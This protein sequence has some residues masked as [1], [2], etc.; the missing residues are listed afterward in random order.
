[1]TKFM[2]MIV[3]NLVTPKVG[4]K[5]ELLIDKLASGAIMFCSDRF[6]QPGQVVLRKVC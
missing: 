1:M 3:M 2:S 4:A 5:N 6:L